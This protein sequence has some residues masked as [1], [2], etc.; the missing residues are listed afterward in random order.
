MYWRFWPIFFFYKYDIICPGRG[1][2]SLLQ[3]S[4]GCLSYFAHFLPDTV[5]YG[6]LGASK[7]MRDVLA[8]LVTFAKKCRMSQLFW[9][10]LQ[11]SGPDL[12]CRILRCLRSVQKMGDVLELL[13]IFDFILRLFFKKWGMYWRFWPFFFYKYDIIC[14]GRWGC[15]KM[16]DVWFFWLFCIL[17]YGMASKNGE[18]I[19]C[20]GHFHLMLWHGFQK[21]GIWTNPI[22]LP[23]Q[24]AI[25]YLWLRA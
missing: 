24:S 22:P 11:K 25:P 1:G 10:L 5:F 9:P 2:R 16:G 23:S 4:A 8:V 12:E 13:A 19:C 21:W 3:K 17:S 6:I 7:K 18:C 14:P 15:Q 20:F